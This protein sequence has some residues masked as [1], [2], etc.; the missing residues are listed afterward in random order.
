MDEQETCAVCGKT[1]ELSKILKH[2]TKAKKCKKYPKD[3]LQELR[4]KSHA[5]SRQKKNCK[6]KAQY[7]SNEKSQENKKYYQEKK[8]RILGNLKEKRQEFKGEM[9]A[10]FDPK[11]NIFKCFFQEIKEGPIYPCI[12][13]MRCLPKR[14][15]KP[16]QEK[17]HQTL[18]DNNMECYVDTKDS[19]KINGKH[20]ICS[21]CQVSLSKRVLPNLCFKNGLELSDVPKCLQTS[22][23]GNQLLAKH[24]TFLKI[25]KLPKT[26][27]G[28]NYDR[29]SI[30]IL[31]I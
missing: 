13:C 16:F 20:Y 30:N 19:L 14:T 27:M 6:R 31:L 12:S 4:E 3:K 9:S 28:S 7:D 18:I 25:R 11:S 22:S 21:T 29:V 5:A 1:L 10:C 8:A 26:R 23:V 24:L 2:I 15:V 17:F